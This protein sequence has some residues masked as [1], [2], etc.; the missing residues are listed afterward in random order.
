MATIF[1][2]CDLVATPSDGRLGRGTGTSIPGRRL[3]NRWS[4]RPRSG[5]M[6][7]GLVDGSRTGMGRW[8]VRWVELR[9]GESLGGTGTV[10]ALDRQAASTGKVSFTRWRE[11]MEA[12]GRRFRMRKRAL[13]PMA[14]GGQAVEGSCKQ[15]QEERACQAVAGSE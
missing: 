15:L 2:W 1:S 6:T 5:A 13:R 14:E 10:A 9:H 3:G 4:C 7:L 11:K 8:Q 12:G